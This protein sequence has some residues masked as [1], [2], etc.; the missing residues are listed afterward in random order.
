[1]PSLPV[2]HE[3]LTCSSR[4]PLVFLFLSRRQF[5]P[6]TS[7]VPFF[8][9]FPI[10]D[11][12]PTPPGFERPELEP[13]CVGDMAGTDRLYP[14]IEPYDLEPP[15]VPAAAGEEEAGVCDAPVMWDDE[16]DAPSSPESVI[17]HS[18][19]DSIHLILSLRPR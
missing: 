6:S 4:L 3:I 16:P 15:Q 13:P 12:P 11:P 9:Q 17:E 2:Y 19:L 8:K 1:M 7:I 10:P 5:R 18:L 14:P